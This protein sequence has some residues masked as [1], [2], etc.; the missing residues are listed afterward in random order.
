MKYQDAVQRNSTIFHPRFLKNILNNQNEVYMY[1]IL[2]QD[3]FLQRRGL[4]DYSCLTQKLMGL[5]RLMDG[6]V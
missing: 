6:C 4:H 1:S 5:D 3:A 2:F